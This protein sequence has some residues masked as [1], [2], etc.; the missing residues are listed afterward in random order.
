MVE[1]AAA[2]FQN[3]AI[4]VNVQGKL[5]HACGFDVGF[6]ATHTASFQLQG[7]SIEIDQKDD[8]GVDTGDAL[9][10]VLAILATLGLIALAAG[11]LLVGIA[12]AFEIL[13]D[14]LFYVGIIA[15]VE[16]LNGG[17]NG[18]QATIVNLNL[19]IPGS[20]VLPTL[21]G[22]DFQV[23]NGVML[24]AATA[25]TR[26]DNVNKH[27]YV[28]FL[29]PRPGSVEVGDNVPLVGVKV[30]M[31]NQDVPPPPGEQTPPLPANT[32]TTIQSDPYS[33]VPSETIST[34]YSFE[35]PTADQTV[36][37]GVTD[38][39]GTVRF[40]ILQ[41]Q[42]PTAGN[43]VAATTTSYDADY[44][45]PITF[46]SET[47]VPDTSPDLYFLVTKADGSVVDSR[48]FGGGFLSNLTAS[49]VGSLS[50]PL[51]ITFGTTVGGNL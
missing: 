10:C 26:P 23:A 34:T 47:P 7:S 24:I 41:A 50:S 42:L 39:D 44:P 37:Q 9:L 45:P 49:Q 12:A 33:E 27:I 3:N 15:L 11:I 16:L 29:I 20:D 17:P 25:G 21:S 22:G 30:V 2:S 13:G 35:P 19:P 14:V 43:I 28:R 6:W 38:L 8:H 32:S 5:V 4:V 1:S 51:T 46:T 18:T 48:Q 31:M 36:A 40:E